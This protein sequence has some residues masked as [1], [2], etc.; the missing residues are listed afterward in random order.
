[1]KTVI[2]LLAI[3]LSS[4]FI[5]AQTS[6]TFQP[7]V[8]QQNTVNVF[9]GPATKEIV[10]PKYRFEVVFRKDSSTVAQTRIDLG[11]SPNFLLIMDD[12][13]NEHA[14]TP[15]KKL[16]LYCRNKTGSEIVG[17]RLIHAGFLKRL[18]EG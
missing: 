2:S 12:R 13:K 3:L 11:I 5:F 8:P 15:T 4:T 17:I 14:I 16:A 18:M 7:H 9:H 1:M 10:T 6:P